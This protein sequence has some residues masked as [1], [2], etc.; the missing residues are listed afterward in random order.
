MIEI[1]YYRDPQ[2][3]FGDD[4]N[5]YIW[6]RVLPA[7]LLSRD[8]IILVGI[9]SILTSERLEKYVGGPKRVAVVGTGISYGTPPSNMSDWYI[10]AVRGPFSAAILERPDLGVTDGAI[11]LA[12]TTDL[13]PKSEKQDKILFMPH[14]SSIDGPELQQAVEDAGMVYVSPQQDTLTVLKHYGT[15]QLVVTEAMHGAIVADTLRIPWIPV[16]L[17]PQ[18]DEF[19]W[20]DWARSMS[21]EYQPVEIPFPTLDSRLRFSAY[22]GNLRKS[23]IVGHRSLEGDQTPQALKGYLNHRFGS[24]QNIWYIDEKT[25]LLRRVAG[26]VRRFTDPMTIKSCTRALN[27]VKAKNPFLSPDRVFDMRLEQMRDAI[28]RTSEHFA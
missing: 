21:V 16:V 5:E 12:D 6:Q 19:K 22:K 17:N 1:F 25:K 10:A 11:L 2:K 28:G 27:V 15:A 13:V 7:S 20:R 4:L 9:G 8:D 18:V 26:K 24:S 23:G 3:N 14:R